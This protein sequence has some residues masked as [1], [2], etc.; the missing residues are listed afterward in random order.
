[1]SLIQNFRTE[2]NLT[3]IS[4]NNNHSDKFLFI[5]SCFASEISLFFKKYCFGY[6]NPYGTIYNPISI[7]K[8]LEML[9][10]K[11]SFNKRNLVKN[12]G[13]FLSW[14]HSGKYYSKSS[15]LL[16]SW[17]ASGIKW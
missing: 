13:V 4:K 6:L 17:S 3:S 2:V 7:A 8:N 10:S 1:M 15:K 9:I 11:D 16:L 5:G 12:N 14:N